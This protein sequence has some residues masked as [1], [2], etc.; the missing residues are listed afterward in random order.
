MNLEKWREIDVGPSGSKVV[1]LAREMETGKTMPR[2][3]RPRTI[4]IIFFFGL[5]HSHSAVDGGYLYSNAGFISHTLWQNR[6]CR[7]CA[8]SHQAPTLVA[9]KGASEETEP[10]ISTKKRRSWEESYNLL[11]AYKETHGH[12]DIPQSAKPLGPWIN[13]QRIEHAKYLLREQMI[14]NEKGDYG[15]RKLPRTSMTAHRKKLLDE[16]GF[17]WDAMGQTWDTRYEEL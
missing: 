17:V 9:R 12:H 3:M 6:R 7:C 10:I 5:S 4:I 14:Q 1:H 8:N 13:R 15:D 16:F 11:C 2:C